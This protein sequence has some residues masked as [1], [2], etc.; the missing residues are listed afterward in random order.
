M[1]SGNY[2]F[3]NN[4]ITY[5]ISVDDSIMNSYINKLN[6]YNVKDSYLR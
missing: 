3:E 2:L 4:K 5:S 6:V 1:D